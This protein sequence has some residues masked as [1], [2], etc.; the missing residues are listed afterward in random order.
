MSLEG[1]FRRRRL[2]HWDVADATYFIT[3]CLAGSIPAAGLKAL[4]AYR[5]EL[6]SRPRPADLSTS[7]C[8][9]RKHKLVF[10]RLDELLDHE[11]AV[12]HLADPQ[13]AQIVHDALWFLAG[14]RYNLLAF[15]VMPS[16]LHWVISPTPAYCEAVS[17]SSDSRTPRERIMEERQRVYRAAVQSEAGENRPF[18]AG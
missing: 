7:D 11:P 3:T 12:R 15:V 5:D 6:D 4:H 18:L 13:L 16:H 17:S 8:E 2:P 9:L 1:V 10:K 14:E